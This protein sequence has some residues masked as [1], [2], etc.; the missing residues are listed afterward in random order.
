MAA[1]ADALA[2]ILPHAQRLTL[3]GQ[4]HDVAAEALAPV[5]AE[6]FSG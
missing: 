2:G 1:G 5:L 4:T 6:F 3:P